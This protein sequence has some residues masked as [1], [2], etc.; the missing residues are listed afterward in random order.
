MATR[1]VSFRTEPA[2]ITALD[3]VADALD[4]DRSYVI[5]EALDAY[6]ELHRWQA[7]HIAAAK[8]EAAAG[9]PFVAHADV[10]AWIG[11]A[12]RGRRGAPPRATIDK[13]KGA[14][15]RPKS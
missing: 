2:K 8:A 15:R 3:H 7:E 12:E 4:R 6:L 5:N 9:G 1:Q 13:R 11:K 10:K 14:R